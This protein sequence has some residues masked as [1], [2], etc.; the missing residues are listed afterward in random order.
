[1]EDEMSD[2]QK[3]ALIS[4]ALSAIVAVLAVFGYNVVVVQP[5][6][7]ALEAQVGEGPA[8]GTTNFGELELSGVAVTAPTSVGTAT[9]AAIIDSSGV[10]ALF[11]VR[12]SATPQ[13]R[14]LNGGNVQ[15]SAAGD[16]PV[17]NA[18]AGKEYAFGSTG[19]IMSA[20]VV[21][22]IH[23]LSTVSAYGCNVK[24]PA[25]N[26]ASSCGAGL[27]SSNQITLTLYNF[28]GTPVPTANARAASWWASGN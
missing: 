7:A 28:S 21:P 22:T 23:A 24:A 18:V 20:T 27:G 5:Q 25:F 9:P 17:E 8:G 6:I 10:S 14:V 3:T 16:Y 19:N 12:D 4:I 11:E 26:G 2:K 13:F 1:M 15:V